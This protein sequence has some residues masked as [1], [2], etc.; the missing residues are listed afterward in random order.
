MNHDDFKDTYNKDHKEPRFSIRMSLQAL[1]EDWTTNPI[2]TQRQV[3]G[4]YRMT[5]DINLDVIRLLETSDADFTW[6]DIDEM[7]WIILVSNIIYNNTSKNNLI[8]EDGI[9][10]LLVVKYKNITGNDIV[11]APPVTFPD[12]IVFDQNKQ[13][14][15]PGIM[16]LSDEECSYID[17]M[18]YHNDIYKN[19]IL[20]Q[21]DML[22]PGVTYEKTVSKRLKD[23]SHNN[24]ELVGTLDKA[25]FV[26]VKQAKDKGVDQDP[27]VNVLERDFFGK[28]IGMGVI[29]PNQNIDVI[30]ELKYDGVSVE[31]DILN[32]RI[33]SARTR[34]DTENDIA[35]DL[36]P[37]LAG[38]YLP[39]APVLDTVIGMKFEAIMT[40]DNLEIYSKLKGYKFANGR[41]A[42][43]SWTTSSDAYQLRELIT[44]VPLAT[45]IKDENGEPIDRLVEVDLMNRF[46][47]RGELLR[48]SVFS[49]NI[50]NVLFEIY[51]FAEEAEFMRRVLP[52][53]YDGIVVSYLDPVIRKRLGRKNSVNLYSMAVKFNSLVRETRFTEYKYTIGQN[54]EITPMIYYNPVEFFGTIHPKSSGHSYGRFKELGLRVGD[55]IEVEYRNDVITYVEKKKCYEN[56]NNPNPVVTFPTTCPCCGAPLKFTDS[57]A[58]CVNFYCKERTVKRMANMM[59]KLQMSGFAEETIRA[60]N[61]SSFHELMELKLEDISHIGDLT[62]KSLIEQINKLKNSNI[63]D[64]RLVGALGFSDLAANT[65][66][67]IFSNMTLRSFM[68]IMNTSYMNVEELINDVLSN[69]KGIGPATIRTIVLEY[70]YFAEDLYYIINHIKYQDSMGVKLTKVRFTGVRNKELVD[71]LN[72]NG[73]DAGEG[74]ITKDTDILIVPSEGY[75][76]GS[77][78]N[79][80]IQNGVTIK[81]IQTFMEELGVQF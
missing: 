39:D 33:I 7:E 67:L 21:R 78:Y 30:V 64:W 28:H 46:Y 11:G 42:I 19:K 15:I 14:L 37:I 68:E 61:V 62:S 38:Y 2:A 77:K 52:F 16:Y 60:L 6:F 18:L 26:L 63:L 10:D 29:D 9:Y 43:I 71:Y 13:E 72:A 4:L 49:G 66:K 48:Y 23:T 3:D 12:D 65:W 20:T 41:T 80:A 17:Q 58:R 59:D 81:P 34:G 40:Y 57:S 51:K 44:L 24:P 8:L 69:I 50:V 32:Q 5:N 47:C 36:T 73:Y 25:K 70:L 54:G 74:S 76:T 22:Y 79:K 35:T 27:T 31:A 55:I 75:N 53:M 1:V 56:D 45:N